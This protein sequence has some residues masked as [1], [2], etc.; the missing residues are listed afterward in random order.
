M[1]RVFHIIRM[2][3][4]AQG[5]SLTRSS[6]VAGPR[7]RSRRVPRP[8]PSCGPEPGWPPA[9]RWLIISVGGKGGGK[10]QHTVN[11]VL[12]YL[13]FA[14]PPLTK[15]CRLLGTGARFRKGGLCMECEGQLGVRHKRGWREN[16]G[17]FCLKD[18]GLRRVSVTAQSQVSPFYPHQGRLRPI[19][20]SQ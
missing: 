6:T 4:L 1:C 9:E 18:G 19:P 8:V 15:F 13:G 16:R 12:R 14:Q 11:T 20:K 10:F 5:G 7:D 2:L 3:S 17:S